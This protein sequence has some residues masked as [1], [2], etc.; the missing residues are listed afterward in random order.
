MV[1][2]HDRLWDD[3][4][5]ALLAGALKVWRVDGRVVRHPVRPGARTIEVGGAACVTVERDE[6]D[7]GPFW[8]VAPEAGSESDLPA[9]PYAGIQGMLRAVR[10]ILAPGQDSTRLVIGQ[11]GN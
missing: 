2:N 3:R 1:T 7:E 11:G 6:E 10:D 9:L 5:E 4:L 8:N